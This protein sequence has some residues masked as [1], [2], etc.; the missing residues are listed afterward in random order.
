MSKYIIEKLP[1]VPVIDKGKA[2]FIHMKSATLAFWELGEGAKIPEHTHVNE[3]TVN[4]LKGEVRLFVEKEEI[5]LRSGDSYVI[6]SNLI[7]SADILT[8]TKVLDVF[9]PIREDLKALEQDYSKKLFFEQITDWILSNTDCDEQVLTYEIDLIE[10]SILNSLK[11]IL[12][13][14]K[15]EELLNIVIDIESIELLE[16]ISISSIYNSISKN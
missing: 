3:M 8:D 15:I 5:M 4:V 16:T 7:H 9:V 13:Y 14:T 6:A 2:R 12:F 10:N 1:L 11:L